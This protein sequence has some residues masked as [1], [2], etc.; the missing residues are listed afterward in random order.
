MTQIQEGTQVPVTHI[1]RSYPSKTFDGSHL[2]N[3]FAEQNKI[4]DTRDIAR[5]LK[6]STSTQANL[7]LPHLWLCT[8]EANTLNWS[9][10]SN[11]FKIPASTYILFLKTTKRNS[12]V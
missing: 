1:R 2:L 12:N 9:H 3:V 7:C 8:L 5:Y 6:I 4:S 11:K 10:K